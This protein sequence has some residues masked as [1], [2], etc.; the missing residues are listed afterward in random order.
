MTHALEVVADPEAAA[1]RAA[2]LVIER[3]RSAVST[4]GRFT[5]AVSGG[6]TAARMLALMGP[7]MPWEAT[8]V[9]QVD[10]RVAPPDHPDRNLVAQMAALRPGVE[11]HPM[12][13]DH[14]D[15]EDAAALYAADLPAAFDLLHLGIGEDG[16]TASLVPGDPVLEVRHRDVAI[17]GEYQGRRR[18]TLTY[19]ALDRA[20]EAIWLVTGAAKSDALRRL[21]GHDPQIP[22]GRV[23]TPSQL[24]VADRAA[25]AGV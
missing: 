5:F 13:V 4:V 7:T 6:G 16:H 24:I 17:S 9:W 12:P 22:A 19:A 20:R 25:A 18:M 1:A 3:A 23:R 2:E 15:L 21:V 14:P 11:L 8:G 10:E